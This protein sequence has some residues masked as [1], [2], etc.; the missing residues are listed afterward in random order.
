MVRTEE[1]WSGLL[2]RL[3]RRPFTKILRAAIDGGLARMQPERRV[4][5]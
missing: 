2:A 4:T 3:L 5:P 1:T